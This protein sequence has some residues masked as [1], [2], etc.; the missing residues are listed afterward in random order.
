MEFLM[1]SKPPKNQPPGDYAVGYGRPPK[2]YQFKKGEPPPARGSRKS[3]LPD[4]G[5]AALLELPVEITKGGETRK[6]S[7]YES[8]LMS[9][10]RDGLRGKVSAI[11]HILL[12]CS[13]HGVFAKE[14]RA[15]VLQCPD[16]LTEEVFSILVARLRRGPPYSRPQRRSAAREYLAKRTERNKRADELA[17]DEQ[18]L[19]EL[20]K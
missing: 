19:Q 16:D 5:L 3:N 6:V 15:P 10:G 8:S 12:E 14:E 13:K 17:G 20:A 18:M 7:V 4:F 2:A 1:D 9:L 11:K